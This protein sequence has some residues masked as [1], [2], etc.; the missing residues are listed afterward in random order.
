MVSRSK[1]ILWKKF[2]RGA[3]GEGR[4]EGRVVA[5]MR[6]AGSIVFFLEVEVW[7]VEIWGGE[8]GGGRW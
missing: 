5:R 4:K 1:A 2:V 8:K 6:G 3:A 7:E